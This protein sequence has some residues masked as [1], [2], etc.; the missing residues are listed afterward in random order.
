MVQ[1]FSKK[2]TEDGF[3]SLTLVSFECVVIVFLHYNHRAGS[4]ASDVFTLIVFRTRVSKGA[5]VIIWL[6]R[7]GV[8]FEVK[9]VKVSENAE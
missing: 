2:G 9:H 1:L 7:K 8:V 4:L 3:W 6:P 5:P